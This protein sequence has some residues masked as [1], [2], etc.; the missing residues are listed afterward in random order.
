VAAF[1]YILRCADG[2]YYYGSTSDL[3]RRLAEHRACRVRS[4]QWRLPVELVYFEEHETLAEARQREHLFKKG[5]TRRK[6]IDLLIE[7]FPKHRLAPFA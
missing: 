2:R 3:S 6:T 1:A 7:R 5:R 4:T